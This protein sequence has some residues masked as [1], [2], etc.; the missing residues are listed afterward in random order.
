M[1][2]FLTLCLALFSIGLLFNCHK[3]EVIKKDIL[4]EKKQHKNLSDASNTLSSKIEVLELKNVPFGCACA[5]WIR[6]NDYE[7]L[8][9]SKE[10]SSG[11]E[12]MFFIEPA[13]DSL[14][15]P[16]YFDPSSQLIIVKGQF[17]TKPDYP[18]SLEADEEMTTT[19]K[20]AP[21]FRYTEIE[22]KQN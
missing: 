19:L 16:K 2:N 1:K 5:D 11:Q 15:V 14:A 9:K 10:Q 7:A 21:V 4:S 12:K 6:K 17:Y 22:V 18:K 3:K 20:K 8:S 13:N